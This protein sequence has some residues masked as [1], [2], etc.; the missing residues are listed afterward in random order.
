MIRSSLVVPFALC[1]LG[2]PP[3][4]PVLRVELA[5]LEG[6][7]L[8]VQS[9]HVLPITGLQFSPDGALLA[10]RSNDE[11]VKL[12]DL[13]IGRELRTLTGFGGPVYALRFSPDGARVA[14][15][16][17]GRVVRVFDTTT[18]EIL[19]SLEHDQPVRAIAFSPDGS[20]IAVGA[21]R[22]PG[23]ISLWE[24]PKGRL[25][26]RLPV[27]GFVGAIAF[28]GD[29]RALA[30]A[31]PAT[32]TVRLFDVE[33]GAPLRNLQPPSGAPARVPPTLGVIA[34]RRDGKYLVAAGGGL[35]DVY[36]PEGA[37]PSVRL[38]TTRYI[39]GVQFA[40]AGA[41]LAFHKEGIERWDL[42][43]MKGEPLLAG[44]R[45]LALKRDGTLWARLA[46][47]RSVAL[48]D[49]A[50]GQEVRRL[51]SPRDI[52][53]EVTNL[54]KYF[55]VAASPL[56][57][58]IAFGG[59]DGRVRIWNLRMGGSPRVLRGAG[60]VQALAFDPTGRVLASASGPGLQLWDVG[61]GT[62]L[63]DLSLGAPVVG[64]AFNR[65]G[66][67]LAAL[68][69]QGRLHF[70]LTVAGRVLG[71]VDGAAHP[72]SMGPVA[73]SGDGRHLL[74]GA[75]KNLVRWS[76]QTQRRLGQSPGHPAV[77]N[78][79]AFGPRGELAIGGGHTKWLAM[80]GAEAPAGVVVLF[81][82]PRARPL[83]LRGHESLVRAV[84]FQPEGAYLASGS[85]DGT[86]KLW[87]VEDGK[88]VA[89]FAAH[90]GDVTSV[91]FTA[92]GR[93]AVSTGLDGAV[94][95]WEVES[96]RLAA[97]LIATGDDDF[98]AALPE[99]Y[100]TASRGG[101][102]SVAFRLGRRVLPL[103][104]FDLRLNRPDIVWSRIGYALPPLLQGYKRAHDRRVRKMGIRPEVLA[105]DFEPPTLRLLTRPP[106]A[107]ADRTLTVRV[108]ARAVRN[109]LERLV[110]YVNDV[111]LLGER[112]ID[113][114]GRTEQTLDLPI[115][116]A[117]GD[118]KV[119][120][121]VLN[122]SGIESLRETFRIA[123]TG[124]APRPNL[125]VLAVGV[126]A[127]ADQALQL[128]FA[129]K[130][131]RDIAETLQGSAR[132]FEKVIV[133]VVE[134]AGATRR[135]ILAAKE[136]LQQAQIDDQVAL[137]FAGHG[138]LYEGEYYFLPA[139]FDR[140]RP[141]ETGIPYEAL[142]GLVEGLSAR[143]KLMMLDT[144]HSGE[145]DEETFAGAAA[146]SASRLGEGIR[147]AR[148]FRGVRIVQRPEKPPPRGTTASLLGELF[149]D[150]RRGP[151]AV[152]IAAA[153]A[154]EYALEAASWRNG[155]FTSCVIDGVRTGKAD[156]NKDGIAQVSELQR[157]V[158]GCVRRLTAGQQ[159]PTSRR[160]N[161]EH[162]FPVH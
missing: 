78:A 64:L 96:R 144:C 101:L 112:G 98:V 82:R 69:A 70:V 156:T 155:V 135:G 95:L 67:L 162:D 48:V 161:L 84:A 21:D 40:A 28:R 89:S 62:R 58:V 152:V 114:R 8:V 53:F 71:S 157:Y 6:A 42:D 121:S 87:R 65:N 79:L 129:A 126:S 97:T 140:G 73:F 104:Q 54:T 55:S 88:E 124:P 134:D 50:S 151:G 27:A 29:G 16:G 148:S 7:E 22:G 3:R 5:G 130:D 94:R 32:H 75:G 59:L 107:T 145:A 63:H 68:D 99:Q 120:I 15:G 24:V 143:R 57:P 137:F 2:C 35:V 14:A 127:Y 12:W 19:A 141:A 100:Y 113:L 52:P 51:E 138:I 34:F 118:N 44:E 60:I 158:T 122:A 72:L 105:R 85:G 154:A 11:S 38:P 149:A 41:L 131:A 110:V 153:G 46:G 102:R 159:S 81:R 115:P 39:E 23:A 106:A 33:G 36:D 123:Y 25:H 91:A 160:E 30:A 108:E 49:S 150:L 133:R 4:S 125:Y 128:L 132:S 76:P 9:G 142:E 93:Y 45:P 119:Q 1:A 56:F 43:A 37:R 92:D 146:P 17:F 26:R 18:G 31:D 116:L 80:G 86:L 117:A 103:D 20:R 10:T 13:R 90:A 74:T 139:D 66:G 61:A 111:R 77:V 83:L 109:A 147:M 47:P 136:F